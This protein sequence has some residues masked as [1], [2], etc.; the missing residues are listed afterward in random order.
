MAMIDPIQELVGD[1][2]NHCTLAFNPAGH[3]MFTNK[4]H[5]PFHKLG[6]SGLERLCFEILLAQGHEPRFFGRSG[7]SQYGIDLVSEKDGKTEVFQCKNIEKPLSAGDLLN[8]LYKFEKEWIGQGDLPLPKRFIICCPQSFRDLKLDEAWHKL[9]EDFRSRTGVESGIWHRDLLEG[10]LKN[11]PDAVADLFSQDH[12]EAFCNITD[13]KSDLFVPL[14]EHTSGDRRLQRY[15]DHRRNGR[16]YIDEDY[17]NRII[18]TLDVSPVI[19]IRG[20]PGTGKTFTSFAIAEHYQYGLWRSYFLDLGYAGVDEAV[21]QDGIHRR[22]SRPSIFLLENC[23]QS[24]EAV[25]RALQRIESELKSGRTKVI[26]LAR[27]VPGPKES[28]SDD[29]ELFY[30]LESRN[31]CVEFET[32]PKLFGRIVSFWRPEF[33]C[34]SFRIKLA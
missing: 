19:L 28:R 29:F 14:T 9:K 10:F 8:W 13:W 31:A 18:D 23:H 20:L 4:E 25:E 16:L 3:L 7:Q 15:F 11:M 24:I 26:C 1:R 30:E 5:L 32:T 34:V 21:L 6:G 2:I 22:R 17:E 12:A 27:S 33:S